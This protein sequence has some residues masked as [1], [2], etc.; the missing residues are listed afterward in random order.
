MELREYDAGLSRPRCGRRGH[1]VAVVGRSKDKDIDLVGV[2]DIQHTGRL[3]GAG[4]IE[5]LK[6]PMGRYK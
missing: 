3:P 4:G 1:S 5:G 2:P 6:Y